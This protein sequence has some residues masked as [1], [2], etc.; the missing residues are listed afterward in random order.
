MEV[1][2]AIR[3]KRAVREVITASPKKS[4][5]RSFNEVVHWNKW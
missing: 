3:T 5:R 4:G 1:F 2:E